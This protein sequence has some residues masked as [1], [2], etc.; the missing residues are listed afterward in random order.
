MR[1]GADANSSAFAALSQGKMSKG[2]DTRSSAFEATFDEQS[3]AMEMLHA[4][5]RL[6]AA[7]HWLVPTFT[8]EEAERISNHDPTSEHRTMRSQFDMILHRFCRMVG[9]ESYVDV[10]EYPGRFAVRL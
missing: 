3:Y 5:S 8:D 6:T 9:F 7:W 10:K 4:P 2:V 1:K